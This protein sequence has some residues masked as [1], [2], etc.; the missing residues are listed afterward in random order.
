MKKICKNCMYFKD[1][2]CERENPKIVY[3][4]SL[5]YDEAYEY[6]YPFAFDNESCKHWKSINK[7]DDLFDI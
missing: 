1:G 2:F 4:P 5:D 7:Y 6:Q 3:S